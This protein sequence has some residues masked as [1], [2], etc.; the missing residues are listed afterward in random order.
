MKFASFLPLFPILYYLVIFTHS[1]IENDDARFSHPG[2][3]I[4]EMNKLMS[5]RQKIQPMKQCFFL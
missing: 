1:L 4:D 5:G 3:I 2:H